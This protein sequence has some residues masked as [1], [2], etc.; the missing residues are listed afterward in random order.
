MGGGLPRASAPLASTGAL[1]DDIVA[2]GPFW[3]ADGQDEIDTVALAGVDR[4]V[5]L[6]GEANWARE[7]RA[8]RIEAA[9]RRKAA[10]LPGATDD[11]RLAIA[12]RNLVNDAAPTT[13]TVTARDIFS[14]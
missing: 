14:D 8:P 3:R 10:A 6:L 4:R 1:E 13:L 2:T 11:A 7:V 9:L 12:A 5:A